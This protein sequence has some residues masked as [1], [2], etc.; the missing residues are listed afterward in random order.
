MALQ[1]WSEAQRWP[2][3]V[4]LE[5][6]L[7]N[8]ATCASKGLSISPTNQPT[9][10]PAA[11]VS[12]LAISHHK[13]HCHPIIRPAFVEQ[14]TMTFC[15]RCSQL[16]AIPSLATPGADT[17]HMERAGIVIRT[18]ERDGTPVKCMECG[19]R[20]I[21]WIVL[22]GSTREEWERDTRS[23]V[24]EGANRFHPLVSTSGCAPAD[25]L[26]A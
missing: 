4:W 3:D 8:Q 23:L 16:E 11:L 1:C 17:C 12:F 18:L 21:R 20:W 19:A 24:L 2:T 13:V 15:I 7:L 22:S 6:Q 10:R 5:R 25:S 14:S 26:T 9:N